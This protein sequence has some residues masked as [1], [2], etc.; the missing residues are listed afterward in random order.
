MPKQ[1]D[2]AGPHNRVQKLPPGHSGRAG[3]QLIRTRQFLVNG[4]ACVFLLD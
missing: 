3:K 2:E 4:A 1:D